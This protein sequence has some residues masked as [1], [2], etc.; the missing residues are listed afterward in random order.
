MHN[1]WRCCVG[2]VIRYLSYLIIHNKIKPA[3]PFCISGLAG[4][5]HY[6][7]IYTFVLYKEPDY[8]LI[9]C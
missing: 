5:L 2:T 7:D 6:N 4:V 8:I 9:F 3:N 1:F